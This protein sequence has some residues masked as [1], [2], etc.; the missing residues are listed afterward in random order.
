MGGFRNTP[1]V[2]A[3]LAQQHLHE[4]LPGKAHCNFETFRST[5]IQANVKRVAFLR[6]G[7]T[8][9][10]QGSD[11]DRI[12][13][14][15]GRQQ[16]REAG[17]SFGVHL[18]P[19][20]PTLL[21]SPAPRTMETANLFLE[22]SNNYES[23]IQVVTDQVLYDG[24]MQPKGSPLFQKLGYAPLK[25]YLNHQDEQFRLDAQFVLGAYAHSAVDVI[26]NLVGRYDVPQ[27]DTNSTLWIV[28]HAIYLPAAALG[29]ASLSGCKDCHLI[30]SMNT[31]P[32]EGYLIDVENQQA[33]YLTRPTSAKTT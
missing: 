10:S 33:R 13:T 29:V 8:A 3:A 1:V 9:P 6:H 11:F 18:K 22:S 21:S 2:L 30:L 20:Y 27:S 12:L 7:Q 17:S 14:E 23:E 24:T 28:G 15:E 26:I 31:L 16:A 5:L 19:F 32:A 4:W 25:D